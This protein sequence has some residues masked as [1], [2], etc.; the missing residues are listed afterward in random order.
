[1]AASLQPQFAEI[2]TPIETAQQKV[3]ATANQEP[4]ELYWS[5]GKYISDRHLDC[6]EKDC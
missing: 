4:I 2:L 3:I 6:S 1:M 5:V